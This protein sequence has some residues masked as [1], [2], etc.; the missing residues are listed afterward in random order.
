LEGSLTGK[1]YN[2]LHKQSVII[3]LSVTFKCE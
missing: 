1:N 3:E 2:G